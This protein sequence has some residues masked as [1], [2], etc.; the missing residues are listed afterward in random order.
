MT[1]PPLRMRLPR[2]VDEYYAATLHT[3]KPHIWTGFKSLRSI[4]NV[5]RQTILGD[6]DKKTVAGA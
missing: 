1:N 5:T 2:N 6:W 3:M 4:D